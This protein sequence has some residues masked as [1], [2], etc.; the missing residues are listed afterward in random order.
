MSFVIGV[1]QQMYIVFA[2][3]CKPLAG[4]TSVFQIPVYLGIG[5]IYKLW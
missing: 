1:P 5:K 4:G 3:L 2:F